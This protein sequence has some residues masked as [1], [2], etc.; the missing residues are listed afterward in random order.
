MTE[1]EREMDD[2]FDSLLASPSRA[3]T[4]PSK[5][6]Q[7]STSSKATAAPPKSRDRTPPKPK[8][9]RKG[10]GA[11]RRADKM[12]AR[13][14]SALGFHG[15]HSETSSEALTVSVQNSVESPDKIRN[16]DSPVK[17]QELL[18]KNRLDGSETNCKNRLFK[19]FHEIWS[20]MT[21]KSK[22][23]WRRNLSNCEV[24][25]SLT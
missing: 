25:Q 21:L 9:S 2:M 18:R 24:H 16:K 15:Y 20:I 8:P 6:E 7:E 14:D 17:A 3:P 13:P 11:K 19:T 12:V 5:A 22:V 23:S 10:S 1:Q 4:S